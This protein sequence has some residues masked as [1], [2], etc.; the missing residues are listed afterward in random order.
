MR[1]EYVPLSTAVKWDWIENGLST[2]RNVMTMKGRV[3]RDT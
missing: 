3:A 1:L 2:T